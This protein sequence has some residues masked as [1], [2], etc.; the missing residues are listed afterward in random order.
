MGLSG[1]SWK[2]F[3]ICCQTNMFGLSSSVLHAQK[4]CE[5]LGGIDLGSSLGQVLCVAVSGWKQSVF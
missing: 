4:L 1:L 3:H 2:L 5:T